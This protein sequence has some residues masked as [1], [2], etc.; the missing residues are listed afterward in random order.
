MLNGELV[1]NEILSGAQKIWET[2]Q[3]MITTT[4]LTFKEVDKNALE[5]S[6]KSD[7]LFEEIAPGYLLK[8]DGER[9]KEN[10]LETSPPNNSKKTFE[11]IA[12]TRSHTKQEDKNC[13]EIDQEL[14]PQTYGREFKEIASE[15]S[16]SAET[17]K[18]FKEIA[19]NQ[20]D[21]NLEETAPKFPH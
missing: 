12:P 10:A 13:G 17:D 19:P 5:L 8:N 4:Q 7:K 21:E 1:S 14:L 11:E 20:D 9:F 6:S 15:P 3:E 18:L 2:L 16:P